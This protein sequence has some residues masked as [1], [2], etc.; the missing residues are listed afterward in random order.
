VVSIEDR[1]SFLEEIKKNK[2]VEAFLSFISNESINVIPEESSA[3]DHSY[4]R[5]I[6]AI[7]NDDNDEF[8]SIYVEFTS[9]QPTAQSPYVH[10]DFLL[11]VLICGL[12]KYNIVDNSWLIQVLNIRNDS[13]T[14]SLA[15]K[16]TFLN[17]LK[18][19]FKSND[20]LFE[21][22]IVCQN[23][24]DK[25]FIDQSAI[26]S[27][28][29]KI[30][31][32][33]LGQMYTSLF[34]NLISYRAFDV[35]ILLKEFPDSELIQALINFEKIFDQR[36]LWVS[37]FLYFL[38]VGL[39][40]YLGYALIGYKNSIKVELNTLSIF[41]QLLGVAFIGSLN[42]AIIHFYLKVVRLVFG[43]RKFERK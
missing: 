36:A 30:S 40:L 2:K 27:T 7:L 42:K 15:I 43:Y 16:N 35:I 24:V 13:Q 37:R 14:E 34:L 33:D 18:D 39:L 6:N 29:L 28:Y 1:L 23:V 11:F 19:N 17:I 9:R 5:A 32:R 38:T 26:N 20:N 21:I 22:I 10:D 3:T 31:K 41:F 12:K 4:Y 8:S 25:I